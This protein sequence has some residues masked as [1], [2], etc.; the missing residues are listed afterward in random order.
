MDTP[1]ILLFISGYSMNYG[2]YYILPESLAPH[3]S[4]GT[5]RK[6]LALILQKILQFWV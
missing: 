3:L 6:A 5:L 1:E 4:N 2:M